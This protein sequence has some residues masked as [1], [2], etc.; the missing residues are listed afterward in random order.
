ML[1]TPETGNQVD[2]HSPSRTCVKAGQTNTE[3]EESGESD[4]SV[5]GRVVWEMPQGNYAVKALKGVCREP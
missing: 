3:S 1:L 2:V 4:L 5:G